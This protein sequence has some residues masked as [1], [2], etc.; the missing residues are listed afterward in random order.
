MGDRQ[1][2]AWRVCLSVRDSARSGAR[3]VIV[4]VITWVATNQAPTEEGEGE[5]FSVRR[6]INFRG[7]CQNES[8]GRGISS[9]PRKSIAVI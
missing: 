6:E 2:A 5:G 7:L 3:A 9:G 1:K 4:C 8:G